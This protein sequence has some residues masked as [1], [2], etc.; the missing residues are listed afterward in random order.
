[1]CVG[2]C[3]CVCGFVCECVTAMWSQFLTDCDH[4][5]L[6]VQWGHGVVTTTNRQMLLFI[7]IIKYAKIWLGGLYNTYNRIPDLKSYVSW[8]P[9]KIL[10]IMDTSQCVSWILVIVY[11]GYQIKNCVPIIWDII[12]VNHGHLD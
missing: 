8:R 6:R 11:N 7:K 1:M 12:I 2:G 3:V 5:C 10:S 4:I 9:D